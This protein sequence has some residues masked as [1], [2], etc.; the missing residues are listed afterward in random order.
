MPTTATMTKNRAA[1]IR[2]AAEATLDSASTLVAVA[3]QSHHDIDFVVVELAA[4]MR[5]DGR[6]QGHIMCEHTAQALAV[7]VLQLGNA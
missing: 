3:R 7:A 1:A 4:L 2:A 5:D 6:R